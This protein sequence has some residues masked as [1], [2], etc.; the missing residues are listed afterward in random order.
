MCT[1][2]YAVIMIMSCNNLDELDKYLTCVCC[3]RTAPDVKAE[4]A[5]IFGGYERVLPPM[6]QDDPAE[7]LRNKKGVK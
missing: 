5:T 7:C 1:T 2:T 4:Y 3:G 6:C